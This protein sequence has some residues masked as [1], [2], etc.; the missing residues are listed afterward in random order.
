MSVAAKSPT[1]RRRVYGVVSCLVL[2]LVIVLFLWTSTDGASHAK[3]PNLNAGTAGVTCQNAQQIAIVFGEAVDQSNQTMPNYTG[4]ERFGFKAPVQPSE[5]V[6][7]QQKLKARLVEVE[8]KARAAYDN[9]CTDP[10]TA[11]ITDADGKA[12]VLPLV[13]GDQPNDPISGSESNDDPRT[14]P[15]TAGTHG[16]K[17]RTHSWGN[18][19]DLYGNEPWYTG[20]ANNNLAMNWAQDV[21]K[22]INAENNH[23]NRF[24]LAVNVSPKLTD[25]QIRTKA[26]SDGNPN[27]ARLKIVRTDSIV[28]TRQLEDKR[29]EPFI[30]R[31]SMIRVTLGKV[32]F[33]DKGNFKELKTDEG[34]FVDCHNMW[35]LPKSNPTP[36]TPSPSIQTSAPRTTPPN[37]PPTTKPPKCVPPKVENP[38]GNCVLPKDPKEGDGRTGIPNQVKSTNPPPP[39][40]AEPRPSDPPDTYSPP[41]PPNSQP[42]PG[43][44]TTASDPP[45]TGCNPPPGM[46]DC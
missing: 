31:R 5:I 20:C 38:N 32:V 36:T 4:I 43:N 18:L 1:K 24:I 26:S 27:A 22:Y 30:D 10:P 14:L 33:D 39:K 16:D 3:L 21:P 41:P 28:N 11:K 2:S 34:I 46:E 13:D 44:T 19:D 29:C 23:D 25:D 6:P 8:T 17:T 15:V 37:T 42:Q 40:S 9:T 35:R 7:L 12:K 45:A